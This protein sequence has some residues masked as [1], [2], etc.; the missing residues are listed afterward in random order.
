MFVIGR[1]RR[2]NGRVIDGTNNNVLHGWWAG[3]TGVY[4]QRGWITHKNRKGGSAWHI[5]AATNNGL[6]YM[7]GTRVGKNN[8]KGQAPAQ[9][10]INFGQFH[11]GEWTKGDIAE[12][13]FYD[14]HLSESDIQRVSTKLRSKYGIRKFVD[15]YSKNTGFNYDGNGNS[16]YLDRHNLDC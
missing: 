5:M 8:H 15:C 16:V 9:W 3:R 11:G 14:R 1:N 12:M 10:T 2:G 4:H 6:A 13:L 7:D